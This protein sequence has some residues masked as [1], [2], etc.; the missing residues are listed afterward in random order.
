MAKIKGIKIS[1]VYGTYKATDKT[2][3]GYDLNG[4]V[5][6]NDLDIVEF[7]MRSR[8]IPMWLQQKAKKESAGK[9]VKTYLKTLEMW[10]DDEMQ[11][12]EHE[13]S[14]IGKDIKEMTRE[15]LQDLALY[16]DLRQIPL[17]HKSSVRTMREKAYK[18]YKKHIDDKFDDKYFDYQTAEPLIVNG[19]STRSKV[20]SISNEALLDIREKISASPRSMEE[21]KQYADRLGIKYATTIGYDKLKDRILQSCDT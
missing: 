15:E 6:A 9:E 16:N 19:D 18:A 14:F 1:H 8:H 21:L 5:P 2:N 3:V 4:I 7:H 20:E 11:E 10:I 17:Y 13:F 12:V